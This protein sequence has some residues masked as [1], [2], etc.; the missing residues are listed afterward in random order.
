MRESIP[1]ILKPLHNDTSTLASV[2]HVDLR[3]AA[4]L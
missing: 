4:G 1:Y 3:R 2:D